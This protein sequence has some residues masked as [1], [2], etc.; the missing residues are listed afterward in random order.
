MSQ[1]PDGRGAEARDYL[2]DDFD[3]Q[4]MDSPPGH[5]QGYRD[6]ADYLRALPAADDRMA[7]LGEL[8]RPFLENDPRLG[9]TLYPD[10]DAIRFMDSLVPDGDPE[11][12]DEYLDEFL[13]HLR[14]DRRRWLAHVAA[15]GADAEWTLETGRPEVDVC[16]A[17]F[18]TTP[19]TVPPRY[20]DW[21]DYLAATTTAERRAMCR[22]RTK[23][24]NAPRLMSEAPER[25]LTVANA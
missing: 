5:A 8:L 19:T 1:E 2:A 24:A 10:G 3:Q 23:K 22:T 14:A 17:H 15:R 7:E 11:V 21:E 16:L 18:E 12:C 9:G 4:A 20:A 25:R 6:F 13:G